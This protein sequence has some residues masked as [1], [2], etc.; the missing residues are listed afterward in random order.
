MAS[1]T[2]KFY[3]IVFRIASEKLEKLNYMVFF[4]LKKVIGFPISAAI[5]DTAPT[6]PPSKTMMLQMN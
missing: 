4:F 5:A 3:H 6:T 1:A 2:V